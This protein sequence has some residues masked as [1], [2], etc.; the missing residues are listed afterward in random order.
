MRQ[1][2]FGLWVI[3]GSFAYAGLALLVLS[4]P[5]LLA[6]GIFGFGGFLLILLIF[7]ALFFV[8]A[9]FALR[10]KRLAYI[11]GSVVAIVLVLLFATTIVTGLSN[12]A[13]SLF[14]L[15]VSLLPALFLGVL[16]SILSFRNAKE[17]V[18]QKKYLATPMSSG[19][20]LTVAVIGFVIGS[21]AASRGFG[22][23][24]TV[25]GAAFLLAAIALYW[26]PDPRSAELI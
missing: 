20:L 4:A 19:G 11:L 23:A 15:S 2:P 22:P 14:W 17:G 7:I 26:V 6:E 3:A 5:A 24:F 16:F 8:A 12:P 10:Q 13:D 9:A 21:L 1:I 25:A 18:T